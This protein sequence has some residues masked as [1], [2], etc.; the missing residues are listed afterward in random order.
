MA[1]IDE[2]EGAPIV[3][4]HGNPTFS[5]VGEF[6]HVAITAGESLD[7]GEFAAVDL[8]KARRFFEVRFWGA[9]TAAKYAARRIK[10]TGS[11]ILTNGII[12]LRP[13]KGWV[14][15]AGICGAVEAVTRALAIELAPVRVNLVCAGIVRT[16]LWRNMS[17]PDPQAAMIVPG[18][19]METAEQL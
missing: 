8:E 12:G 7:L 10:S 19:V 16:E 3:F 4:A 5:T 14:I 6:D 9:V 13:Q 15:A 11:I 17:E 1:Y 18:L 2:G